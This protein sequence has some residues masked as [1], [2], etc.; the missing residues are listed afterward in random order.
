MSLK[1]EPSSEQ[2]LR[3][4]KLD[5]NSA[6]EDRAQTRR[7]NPAPHHRPETTLMQCG[8]VTFGGSLCFL[9]RCPPRRLSRLDL[10]K[11]KLA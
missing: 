7:R 9:E 5:E 3:M 2:A 1:Y 8:G 6:A 4:A 10:F 11:K